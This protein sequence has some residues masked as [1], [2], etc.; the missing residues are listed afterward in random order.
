MAVTEQRRRPSPQ[1]P[2]DRQPTSTVSNHPLSAGQSPAPAVE[3]ETAPETPETLH[4]PI[5][6]SDAGVERWQKV[7]AYLVMPSPLAERAPA[8]AQI[9]AYAEQAPWTAKADGPVRFAGILYCRLIAIP[10]IVWSRIRE[11]IWQRPAR[12][13][14][15][16]VTVKLL[17]QLPPAEWAVDHLVKP[18][19]G[20]ALW[21]FL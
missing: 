5:T 11:W 15:T 6:K 7:K 17:A 2:T 12:L 21:L 20:F 16:A 3:R 9:K 19:V 18:A 1:P 10:Y 8:V 13:L 14:V 4:S